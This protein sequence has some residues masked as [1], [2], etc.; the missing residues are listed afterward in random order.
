MKGQNRLGYHIGLRSHRFVKASLIEDKINILEKHILEL[1]VTF[2]ST[3][4][5]GAERRSDDSINDLFFR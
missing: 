4:V 5:H 3:H 1:I 2:I